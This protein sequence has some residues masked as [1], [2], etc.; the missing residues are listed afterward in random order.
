MT[1]VIKNVHVIFFSKLNNL[2]HKIICVKNNFYS[3][4]IE[5]ENGAVATRSKFVRC[6]RNQKIHKLKK[7]QQRGIGD[8]LKCDPMFLFFITIKLKTFRVTQNE[9]PKTVKNTCLC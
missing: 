4:S 7:R 5:N 8:L 6:E 3:A 9:T 2:I 1:F